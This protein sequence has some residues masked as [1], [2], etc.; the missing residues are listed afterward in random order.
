MNDLA[1]ARPGERILAA[2]CGSV[3]ITRLAV[4]RT[5]SAGQVVRLDGNGREPAV[6]R[7]LAPISG[8]TVEGLEASA[9]KIPL[10]DATFDM[11]LYQHGLQ[12]FPDRPAALPD[13]RRALSSANRLAL[14]L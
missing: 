3:A 10:P 9:L 11:V 13:I 2:V 7:R 5:G 14:I 1:M 12:Q 8:P 6:V 4:D